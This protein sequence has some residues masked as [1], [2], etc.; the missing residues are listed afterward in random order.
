MNLHALKP[1]PRFESRATVV[2]VYAVLEVFACP[3]CGRGFTR[4]VHTSI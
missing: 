4:S 3:G 1:D 2:T